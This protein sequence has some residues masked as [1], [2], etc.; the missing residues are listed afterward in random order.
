MFTMRTDI[1]DVPAAQA[2]ILQ[3][4]ETSSLQRTLVLRNLTASDLTLKI[5]ESSD[6]T[7]WTD[8]AA[9]FVLGAAGAGS[10]VAIKNLSTT[11]QF[12]LRAQGGDADRDLEVALLSLN[13][14]ANHLWASP[15]M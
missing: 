1:L 9:S 7:T 4:R 3:D 2:T 14:D 15:I 8:V 11:N 5:Q 13:D 10:D 12:R 6:G